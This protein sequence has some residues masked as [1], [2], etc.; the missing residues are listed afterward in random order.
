MWSN[1]GLDRLQI[2][3]ILATTQQL[4]EVVQSE[5]VLTPGPLL[6]QRAAT[7]YGRLYID[8]SVSSFEYY[9]A[10]FG[11]PVRFNHGELV[12]VEPSTGCGL[13]AS[14]AQDLTGK[15]AVVERGE[16]TFIDKANS[17]AHTKAAAMLVIN[18]DEELFHLAAGIAGSSEQ[19]K[20]VS[21]CGPLSESNCAWYVHAALYTMHTSQIDP[22]P[23]DMAVVLLHHSALLGLQK[24]AEVGGLQGRLIPLVHTKDQAASHPVLPEE[25]EFAQEV[26]CRCNLSFFI[27]HAHTILPWLCACT[28]GCL[29]VPSREVELCNRRHQ[30]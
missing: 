18:S 21:C 14:T 24:A 5:T 3:Q 22:G 30:H 27:M 11:G 6:E 9:Q 4:Q 7:L 17:V 29:I 26:S 19:V 15:L 10:T 20:E 1:Q 28:C 13:D 25:Q 8:G 16:C 12:W 2:E 23:P